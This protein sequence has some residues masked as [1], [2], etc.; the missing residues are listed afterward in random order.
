MARPARPRASKSSAQ[1]SIEPEQFSSPDPTSV[2]NELL[3]EAASS[4]SQ[5][6][7]RPLKRRK[8]FKPEA[9]GV[10]VAPPGSAQSS[11]ENASNQ[12]A[13]IQTAFTD[14]EQSEDDDF[15]WEDV[16][17]QQ[18][19]TELV[20][21][22][23]TLPVPGGITLNLGDHQPS[24][25]KVK[26]RAP[27]TRLDK[28]IK[29]QAHKAHLLGLLIHAYRRNAW[30]NDSEVQELVIKMVPL[31]VR[32]S[33][34]PN[35]DSS[36]FNKDRF[37]REGLSDV[38][39]IWKINFKPTKQGIRQPSWLSYLQPSD[40]RL[41]TDTERLIDLKDFRDVA[42]L[43]EGSQDTG[44]QLL[45]AALRALGVETR[46]VCS[47]QTLSLINLPTHFCAGIDKKFDD[48]S[49]DIVKNNS[50]D[51]EHRAA[52]QPG[53]Q[54]SEPRRVKRRLGQPSL[55]S[56]STQHAPK[57]VSRRLYKTPFPVYWVEAFNDALQKWTPVEPFSTDT[58]GKPS[59]LEPPT[60]QSSKGVRM[61]YVIAFE[62]DGSARDVTKRYASTYNAKTRKDRVESIEGGEEWFRRAMKIFQRRGEPPTDRDQVE[63]A[64]FVKKEAQ[65][66]M[67]RA[68]QDFKGHP[69]YALER[70]L[71]RNEVI[72]PKREVGKVGATGKTAKLESVYRRGDV[73]TVRSADKWYRLGREILAGEQPLKHV[74][75]KRAP[76][77]LGVNDDAE[78]DEEGGGIGTPLYASFQTQIY[79]PPPCIRGRVPKN[80]FGNIDVYVP[81][82]IPPGGKHIRDPEASRAAKLLGI[83]YADAV[84]GFEFKG[85]RGTA[86]VQGI[87]VAEEYEAGVN[88]VLEA[89]EYAREQSEEDARSL[90]A[91]RTWK[92][93][94]VGLRVMQRVN[95][96]EIEGEKGSLLRANDTADDVSNHDDESM[97]QGG[98]FFPDADEDVASPTARQ[99]YRKMVEESEADDSS[100]EM[101][102][103]DA[104]D[105]AKSHVALPHGDIDIEGGGGFLVE[106]DEGADKLAEVAADDQS[107]KPDAS[108][109]NLRA[110]VSFDGADFLTNHDQ[111]FPNNSST[112]SAGTSLQT[113]GMAQAGGF[114]LGQD[115]TLDSSSNDSLTNDAEMQSALADSMNEYAE[116]SRGRDHAHRSSDSVDDLDLVKARNSERE[117]VCGDPGPAGDDSSDPI[118]PTDKHDTS[119]HIESYVSSE[120]DRGSLLSHDPEDDEAEPDWLAEL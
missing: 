65:E 93:F 20:S 96:Y 102:S 13:E 63:A 115:D 49:D 84:T 94:L 107:Q 10:T 117:T 2:Y 119:N 52:V 89:M 85:R 50:S 118:G 55:G 48:V 16:T 23:E 8:I 34:M 32:S 83:D 70:H 29:V 51:N 90:L 60:S 75:P 92:R 101:A 5:A 108:P 78:A 120:D 82:M 87:V 1:R 38:K 114:D 26:K 33:L 104:E 45:C 46:L 59:K 72:H 91:L 99:F 14:T 19:S 54:G 64:E 66:G 68:L 30:C 3:A 36:Q 18:E 37:F 53:I 7:E 73:K 24:K 22:P 57:R 35:P 11:S 44:V 39:D 69:V 77:I 43:L 27:G 106:D 95:E 17:L 111:P 80:A 97:D 6:P 25:A 42:K 47:L 109:E 40:F 100:D 103:Q 74:I 9:R 76:D 110:M 105:L 21:E 62:E 15:E 61:T 28:T 113:L 112:H 12:L 86:V 58:V 88:A 4:F 41:A 81:S 79:T 56:T 98:G 116:R 67:P 31:K 71:K